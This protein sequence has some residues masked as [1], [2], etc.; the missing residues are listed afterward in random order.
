MAIFQDADRGAGLDQ[1]M[2]ESV[3]S[4]ATAQL[5]WLSAACAGGNRSDRPVPSIYS[6]RA[7]FNDACT[8][9]LRMNICAPFA[10]IAGRRKRYHASCL[11]TAIW[12][13]MNPH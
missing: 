7:D 6:I 11:L 13:T 12:C 10:P 4:F 5:L 2:A 1:T 9:T 3:Q 8:A